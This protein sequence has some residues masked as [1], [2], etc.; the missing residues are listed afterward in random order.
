MWAD[1][2]WW[3]VCCTAG[4]AHE[5]LYWSRLRN[6]DDTWVPAK[7]SDIEQCPDTVC[8]V[9]NVNSCRSTE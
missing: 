1:V 5:E 7:E 9:L 6:S 8:T 4:A 2:T 3:C